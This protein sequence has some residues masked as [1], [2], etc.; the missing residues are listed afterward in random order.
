MWLSFGLTLLTPSPHPPCMYNR[1]KAHQGALFVILTRSLLTC[2][3]ARAKCWTLKHCQLKLP[4]WQLAIV[5][6]F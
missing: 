2:Q 1:L 3:L 6:N 4:D 5:S